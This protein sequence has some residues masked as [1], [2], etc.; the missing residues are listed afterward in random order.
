[1]T[2]LSKKKYCFPY[3]LA[4]LFCS[5]KSSLL[6]YVA[7]VAIL[8]CPGS[9]PGSFFFHHNFLTNP[10]FGFPPKCSTIRSSSWWIQFCDPDLYISQGLSIRSMY[11]TNAFLSYPSGTYSSI[12][13]I[14]IQWPEM[15]ICWYSHGSGCRRNGCQRK[16]ASKELHLQ[17]RYRF[18]F[19]FLI[20][21]VVLFYF[22]MYKRHFQM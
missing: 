6:N 13:Q 3:S 20:N 21:Y 19:C 9:H 10:L 22:K 1:M 15:H 8:T 7:S 18:D 17:I 11:F 16:H 2:Y 4:K 5:K 12:K 14:H